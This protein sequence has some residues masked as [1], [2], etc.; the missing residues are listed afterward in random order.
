M[1]LVEIFEHAHTSQKSLP[2]ETRPAIEISQT[3]DEDQADDEDNTIDIIG[4]DDVT[5]IRASRRNLAGTIEDD[6]DSIVANY[7]KHIGL[8]DI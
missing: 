1:E 7:T 4:N 8:L 5:Y 6:E 3:S 2:Q